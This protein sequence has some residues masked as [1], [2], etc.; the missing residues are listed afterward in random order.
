MSPEDVKTLLEAM[1]SLPGLTVAGL[2]THFSSAEDDAEFTAGQRQKFARAVDGCS[3]RGRTFEW[4]HASNSGGLLLEPHAPCNTVRA[5][6][7]VYGVVPDGVR[8]AKPS[9]G[10][11]CAAPAW[12]GRFSPALSWK[13]Q[14]SLVKAVPTGTPI[15]YGHTFVTPTP[16]RI[17]ILAAGY[18]DGYLRSGSNRA[19]VL[20]GGQMCPVLGRVTMDQTIVDVSGVENVAVG[21]EAVM[22]GVQGT[23]KITANDL[24]A[25]CQ[26]IPWEILTSIT[27]RVPRIYRGGHAA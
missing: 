17:A 9:A 27:Y 12:S 11:S 23:Q 21:S 5:G 24:A 3:W 2:Y 22:L 10:D 13:C 18:G 19:R 15:S 1:D 20:I 8:L 14:V 25:V 4:I 7:L 6:L 26:T 16:M